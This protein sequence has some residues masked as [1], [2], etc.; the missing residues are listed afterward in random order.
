[1][2]EPL[3][4]VRQLQAWAWLGWA[5]LQGRGE[6]A[7]LPGLEGERCTGIW[8]ALHGGG[9]QGGPVGGQSPVGGR[10]RAAAVTQVEGRA[11][12]R[13]QGQGPGAM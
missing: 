6:L 11:V 3:C 5:C 7:A 4:T 8:D 13:E 1:M 9:V 12:S 10:L 2:N